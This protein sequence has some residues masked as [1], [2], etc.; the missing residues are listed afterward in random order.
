MDQLIKRPCPAIHVQRFSRGQ[1]TY[2]GVER[3]TIRCV[4]LR[5]HLYLQYLDGTDGGGLFDSAAR[6]RLHSV[7][8]RYR[9][10]IHGIFC[11]HIHQVYEGI[12]GDSGVRLLCVSLHLGPAFMYHSFGN[13]LGVFF[14]I[15]WTFDA[16][17]TKCS[18]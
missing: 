7:L 5:A 12:A 3:I 16:S 1:H 9:D 2:H 15:A 8:A 4:V 18:S 6:E 13:S 14:L 10:Q 17:K 11:G